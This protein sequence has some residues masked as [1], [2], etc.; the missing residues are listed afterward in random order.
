MGTVF[1]NT[2]ANLLCTAANDLELTLEFQNGVV[3]TGI[4]NE[5]LPLTE[6][7]FFFPVQSLISRMSWWS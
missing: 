7:F 4:E 2:L 3:V 6:D 5:M 1:V